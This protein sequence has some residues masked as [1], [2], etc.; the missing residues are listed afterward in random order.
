[1]YKFTKIRSHGITVS[2]AE[3]EERNRNRR[4]SQLPD[5]RSEGGSNDS[6]GS[7][8]FKTAAISNEEDFKRRCSKLFK[9]IELTKGRRTTISKGKNNINA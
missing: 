2:K 7:Q 8:R 3:E 1:M 6:Q 4:K 9:G 5:N